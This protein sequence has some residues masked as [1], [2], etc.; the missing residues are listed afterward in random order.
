MK[1]RTVMLI[2]AF[3]VVI[4]TFA[5]T[6]I[7]F[8]GAA[9]GDVNADGRISIVDA[10]WVLLKMVNAKTLNS[11]Q[12]DSADVNSDGRIDLVDAKWILQIVAKLRQPPTT[13]QPSTEPS[14]EVIAPDLG[15]L[16]DKIAQAESI[17]KI[18]YYTDD[19]VAALN[20]ALENARAVASSENPTE[21]QIK[22]AYNELDG[23]ISA[24]KSLRDYLGEA[25]EYARSVDTQCCE[26]DLVNNLNSRLSY[27]ERIFNNEKAPALQLKNARKVL[28]SVVDEIDAYKQ[29]LADA[30]QE[31]SKKI[32]SVDEI[33]LTKKIDGSAY[34]PERIEYLK[35][36]VQKAWEVYS[37]P[38]SNKKDVGTASQGI[39]LGIK[40]LKTY[41]QCLYDSLVSATKTKNDKRDDIIQAEKRAL[42][43]AEQK[44]LQSVIDKEN[45]VYENASSTDEDYKTALNELSAAVKAYLDFCDANTDDG[46]IDWR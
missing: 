32:N 8:A 18:E 15:A 31:L 4:F 29:E 38:T 43:A 3:L 17:E 25:I 45:K 7:G 1:K 39:D 35:Y 28:L 44:K 13:T 19:T 27:A 34:N 36:T 46:V 41:K 24:L 5:I 14:T 6:V 11:Q 23:A 12:E 16:K 9:K 37:S 21:E 33:D 22:A 30:K 26:S 40:R 20:A 10:R 2:S 42:L